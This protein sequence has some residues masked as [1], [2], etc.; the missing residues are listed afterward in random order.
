MAIIVDCETHFNF[1]RSFEAIAILKEFYDVGVDVNRY[2]NNYQ[3][4]TAYTHHC[5]GIE[6]LELIELLAPHLFENCTFLSSDGWDNDNNEIEKH[7]LIKEFFKNCSYNEE[8]DTFPKQGS[9]EGCYVL[10]YKGD[11][12]K[13]T[14]LK[15]LQKSGH[16]FQFKFKEKLSEYN[17]P[18]YTATK[19]RDCENVIVSDAG[20]EIRFYVNED[21]TEFLLSYD[22]D[23]YGISTYNIASLLCTIKR[24]T[25]GEEV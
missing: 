18:Y 21:K 8:L 16:P 9:Y 7:A 24:I 3:L 13:V 4:H 20:M 15:V 25:K 1:T 17:N 5:Y 23:F 22:E 12:S 10:H 6:N 14:D 19:L 11:F 2:A